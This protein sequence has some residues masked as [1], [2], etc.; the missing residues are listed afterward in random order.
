[1][2]REKYWA[3]HYIR[4]LQKGKTVQFRN[5]ER[6]MAPLME[7]GD[8][9][10]MVPV[11]L[12]QVRVGDVVLCKISRTHYLRRVK[13]IRNDQV[14]VEDLRNQITGWSKIV[15]GLVTTVEK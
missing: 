9:V 7:D 12:E 15:Y 6:S 4:L 10:T 11:N 8:L 3:D 1:M 13:E 5:H 2:N 14:L